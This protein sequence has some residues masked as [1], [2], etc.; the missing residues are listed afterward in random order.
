ML[1]LWSLLLIGSPDAAAD[2]CAAGSDPRPAGASPAALPD[3]PDELSARAAAGTGAA[4]GAL[5]GGLLGGTVAI[6]LGAALS[7]A[8]EEAAALPTIALPPLFVAVGA[9]LGGLTAGDGRAGFGAGIGG[10]AGAGVASVAAGLLLLEGGGLIADDRGVT[11]ALIAAGPALVGALVA[12]PCAALLVGDE[13]GLE[14]E[15][16][17]GPSAP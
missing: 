10:A 7:G 6:G 2:C 16:S 11:F 3:A 14:V 17:P 1:A 13:A 12:G 5:V 15:A 8:A 9:G 4:V